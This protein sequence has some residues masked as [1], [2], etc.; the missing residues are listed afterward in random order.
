[1]NREIREAL[2]TSRPG[3]ILG[4]NE[5]QVR[6]AKLLRSLAYEL[7][8]MREHIVLKFEK[9]NLF[10]CMQEDKELSQ[11][12]IIQGLSE[13]TVTMLRRTEDEAQALM[14][15]STKAILSPDSTN[16]YIRALI[17]G[18]VRP[19][20][21]VVRRLTCNIA[22]ILSARDILRPATTTRTGSP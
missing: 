8:L 5:A 9:K 22:T 11:S 15:E 12:L 13:K 2:N 21:R 1:M 7:D 6:L 10:G 3:P 14:K 18:E 4:M 16:S 20:F 19:L 17:D